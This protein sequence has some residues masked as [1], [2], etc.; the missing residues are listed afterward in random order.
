MR[1]PRARA[2]QGLLFHPENHGLDTLNC[3]LILKLLGG[4]DVG[5]HVI[6][7]QASSPTCCL[8]SSPIPRP[9]QDDEG[10]VRAVTR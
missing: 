4:G 8:H 10:L 1:L 2:T 9:S 3:W 6:T 7:G 5:D